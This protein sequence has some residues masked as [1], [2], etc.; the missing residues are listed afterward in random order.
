[1]NRALKALTDM[2]PS[3]LFL[4]LIPSGGED[5][6]SRLLRKETIQKCMCFYEISMPGVHANLA[7]SRT[8]LNAR[9]FLFTSMH[10]SP[11]AR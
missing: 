10:L 5:K 1:M 4:L 2:L 11:T 7:S 6:R 3:I 8:R 9:H